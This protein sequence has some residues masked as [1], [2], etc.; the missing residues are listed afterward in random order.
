MAV[1][2]LCRI[3]DDKEEELLA[4]GDERRADGK[5]NDAVSKCK[6]ILVKAESG[7]P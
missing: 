1:I 5:Y 7:M 3:N 4:E 6:D 2:S